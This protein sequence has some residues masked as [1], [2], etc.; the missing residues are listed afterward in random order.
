MIEKVV[1]QILLRGMLNV[2]GNKMKDYTLGVE[3]VVNEDV[4]GKLDHNGRDL[5]R[6]KFP[7]TDGKLGDV[8]F[9]NPTAR[10]FTKNLKAVIDICLANH[11]E[12]YR[13]EWFRAA[14]LF[15]SALQQLCSHKKF[16]LK[17]VCAFQD[18]ADDFCDIYCR[19]TGIECMTNYLHCLR[20]GTLHTSFSIKV[21]STATPSR[22][23][24]QS[25]VS[26]R[27]RS[28]ITHNEEVEGMAQVNSCQSSYCSLVLTFGKL[29]SLAS[30][31]SMLRMAVLTNWT[32]SMIKCQKNTTIGMSLMMLLT[33][34]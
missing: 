9:S 11:P 1:Q 12:T 17:D 13:S 15:E 10:K 30:S 26:S 31:S 33:R 21:A 22:P 18:T 14:G 28:T 34:T 4:L 7:L 24:N 23:G 16:E 25:M 8:K 20:A 27:E 2:P 5:G 6:W 3:T 32:C 29:W 19:M